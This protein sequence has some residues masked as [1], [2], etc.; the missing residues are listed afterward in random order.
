MVRARRARSVERAS[1][2]TGA[3][4]SIVDWRLPLRGIEALQQLGIGM[5]VAGGPLPGYGAELFRGTE[6][7]LGAPTHRFDDAVDLHVRADE[8]V[9]KIGRAHV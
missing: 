6:Q 5:E 7:N 4:D 2:A 9:E 1:T 8:G 3:E